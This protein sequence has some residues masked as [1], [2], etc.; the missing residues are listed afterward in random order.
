MDRLQLQSACAEHNFFLDPNII[1]NG[2]G[3]R[4]VLEPADVW[5]PYVPNMYE[6][7]AESKKQQERRLRR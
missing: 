3:K 1:F 4:A 5:L 2:N 6:Q 7:I